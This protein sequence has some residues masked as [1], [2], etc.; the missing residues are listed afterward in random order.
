MTPTEPFQ[1]PLAI[2]ISVYDCNT[3]TREAEIL[4]VEK[5]N[6]FFSC[7]K[8]QKK[9]QTSPDS[10]IVKCSN[11]N[12]HQKTKACKQNELLMFSSALDMRT[13]G[14]LY[15]IT[16]IFQLLIKDRK[17]SPQVTESQM[18]KNLLTLPNV[19][20]TYDAKKKI[21]KSISI[22]WYRNMCGIKSSANLSMW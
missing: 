17:L 9:V 19:K 5:L 8:C 7:F 6:S 16:I 3:P 14:W 10:S 20:V 15:L 18:T 1:V 2:P 4:A 11:C 12:I 13:L 22:N 21:V